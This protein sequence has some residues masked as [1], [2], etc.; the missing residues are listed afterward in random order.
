MVS[1]RKKMVVLLLLNAFLDEMTELMLQNLERRT[2]GG[3]FVPAFLNYL[4]KE[5]VITTSVRS[6]C[7]KEKNLSLW[8]WKTR[9]RA[10]AHQKVPPYQPQP[11]EARA[12]AATFRN[13]HFFFFNFFTNFFFQSFL[14]LRKFHYHPT[15]FSKVISYLFQTFWSEFWI[16]R[17]KIV[18]LVL[19]GFDVFGPFILK[20]KHSAMTHWPDHESK[21]VHHPCSSVF[22]D[23]HQTSRVAHGSC[24][25]KGFWRHPSHT[26][27]IFR[28]FKNWEESIL[29]EAKE[30]QLDVVAVSE[31]ETV[32][33][34]MWMDKIKLFEVTKGFRSLEGKTEQLK[35]VRKFY[36]LQL[37]N[38][39]GEKF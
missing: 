12:Q 30:S 29:V 32:Q 21:G 2:M 6:Y 13:K 22:I 5:C 25:E 1:W 31:E 4:K 37:E 39:V 14:W 34:E 24:P 9:K 35:N 26:I 20:R 11:A 23:D 17:R 19:S 10:R 7:V 27:H 28:I 16:D 18:Q 36:F 33:R 38:C 8:I 3:L 15:T